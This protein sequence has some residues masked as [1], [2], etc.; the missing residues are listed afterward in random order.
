MAF[1]KKTWKARVSEAP[2]RR[3][4]TDTT[5]GTVQTVTVQRDEGTITEPGDG[6]TKANMDDLETRIDNAFKAEHTFLTGTLAAGTSSI[7]FTDPNIDA[8]VMPHIYVPMEKNKMV[9]DTITFVQPHSLTITFPAQ[10]TATTIKV[11][12]EHEEV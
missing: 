2:N 4:L 9:P 8:N 5:T 11:K 6:F 12:L 1:S 7:T 3:K 10:N